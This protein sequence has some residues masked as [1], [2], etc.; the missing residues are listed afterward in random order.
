MK[1]K[2]RIIVALDTSSFEQAQDLVN[3]LQ[4]QVGMFKIG[5]QLTTSMII[6]GR[7]LSELA[8]GEHR[9][10]LDLKLHDIPNTMKGAAQSLVDEYDTIWGVTCH[11]TAGEKGMREI[12]EV[13]KPAGIKTIAVTVLTSHDET[14]CLH[15]YGDV[16]RDQSIIFIRDAEDAGCDAIVCS[17]VEAETV[18]MNLDRPLDMTLICPG[19][20]PSW[21]QKDDQAR[22]M[23]PAEAVDAGADYLVIGR[24]ITQ[25]GWT[26]SAAAAAKRIIDELSP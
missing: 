24:P 18:R 3:E 14:D 6:N 2:E 7:S 25:P 11:A 20:R 21:A 19:V 22:V 8:L 12:V 23:T 1:S 5:L 4:G 10:M 15:I 16:A 9:V 26:T 17:P 13:V